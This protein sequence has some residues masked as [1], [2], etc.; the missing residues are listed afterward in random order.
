[1]FRDQKELAQIKAE[2]TRMQ[3]VKIL[4]KDGSE[5]ARQ[6]NIRLEALKDQREVL[7]DHLTEKLAEWMRPSP[8][9]EG[10]EQ[11]TVDITMEMDEMDVTSL[12]KENL[13]QLLRRLKTKSMTV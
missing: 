7:W 6:C 1:M 9:E 10:E 2:E 12:S 11:S 8:T 5:E 4:S 13:Q 3:A